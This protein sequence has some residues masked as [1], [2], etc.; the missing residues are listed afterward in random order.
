MADGHQDATGDGQG[1]VGVHGI[2]MTAVG[3]R[4]ATAQLQVHAGADAVVGGDHL[5]VPAAHAED[6][7]GFDAFGRQAVVAFVVRVPGRG[8]G[9]GDV[10][11]AAV[12]GDARIGIVIGTGGEGVLP[13]LPAGGDALVVAADGDVSVVDGHK[14]QR[15]HGTFLATDLDALAGGRIDGQP[16]AIH[17]EGLGGAQPVAGVHLERQVATAQ[18]QVAGGGQCMVCRGVDAQRAVTPDHQRTGGR[19]GP[20]GLGGFT[21]GIGAA[22]AD[23]GIGQGAVALQLDE[24]GGRR[25]Q[26]QCGAVGTAQMGIGQHQ[27]VGIVAV[28]GE[29][30]GA[31]AGQDIGQ[32]G[33]ARGGPDRQ[34]MTRSRE[35]GNRFAVQQDGGDVISARLDGQSGRGGA[36]RQR[37]QVDGQRQPTGGVHPVGGV[38][39]GAQIP[40]GRGARD[41]GVRMRA[42]RRVTRRRVGL[43]GSRCGMGGLTR[44]ARGRRVM[45]RVGCAAGGGSRAA[46]LTVATGQAQQGAQ[47]GQ[48]RP[49]GLSRTVSGHGLPILW[50][51][52]LTGIIQANDRNG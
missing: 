26:V 39:A 37:V 16:A 42:R 3:I 31:G 22:C 40:A 32:M 20:A 33:V 25:L 8:A 14:A 15:L 9:G 35:G 50:I 46:G 48:G 38:C 44:C 7:L 4:A 13:G 28:Q 30:G 23:G 17:D 5:Q 27:P 12:D 34:A 1:A 11:R 21:L 45:G 51:P 47:Q 41:G 6:G 36:D 49:R 19:E 29:R 24:G 10:D 18:T 52:S 43:A 2:V